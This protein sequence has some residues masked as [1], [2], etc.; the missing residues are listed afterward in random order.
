MF[1]LDVGALRVAPG[2]P[3]TDAHQDQVP[4]WPPRE[5]DPVFPL[6]AFCSAF[7][8]SVLSLVTILRFFRFTADLFHHFTSLALHDPM[9]S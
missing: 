6:C 5:A 7:A 8:P 2:F 4:K 3:F 9:V 1:M